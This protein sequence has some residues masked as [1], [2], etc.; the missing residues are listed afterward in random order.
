MNYDQQIA[1]ILYLQHYS[2]P[3]P[4]MQLAT[5]IGS[6][7]FYLLFISA[8]YWCFDARLG[9]RLGLILMLSQSLNDCLKIAFHSP[10]PYWVSRKVVIITGYGSFGI[11]S[12]H[13]QNAVCVWGYLAHFSEKAYAWAAA[14]ALIF[15]IGL[16]RMYLGAHF[17]VDVAAGWAVGA[18]ILASFVLLGPKGT[19][20][21][22]SL[23]LRRQILASFLASIGLV[24]LFFLSLVSL[25]SWQV[26]QLWSENAMAAVNNPINPLSYVDIFGSAGTLFGMSA[27]YSWLFQRT[28]FSAKG[29]AAMRLLRYVLGIAGLVLIRYVFV[30]IG[31]QQA[32]IIGYGIDYLSAVLASI[33]VAAVA[34][35]LFIRAG[36]AQRKI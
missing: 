12:G 33:W 32:L 26:P 5:A 11:P 27:G 8:I 36:L 14:F 6:V 23:G 1:F 31:L 2:W 16:S 25:G 10:R 15:T 28:G 18:I 22:Q 19:E 35:I 21:F 29:S 30:A 17:P 3:L 9:F 20:F 4:L 13:A 7:E 34:P 24:A